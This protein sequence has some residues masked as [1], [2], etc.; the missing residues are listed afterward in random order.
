V[1]ATVVAV[2]SPHRLRWTLVVG[3]L[4]GLLALTRTNG[5]VVALPVALAL[6]GP[7][8]RWSWRALAPVALLLAVAAA[9]VAP[10]T[11]RNARAMDGFVPVGTEAGSALAGTYN[12]NAQEQWHYP[13]TWKWPALLPVLRPVLAVPKDEVAR[14]H[15]LIDYALDYVGD[16]PEAPFL[17]IATNTGR[18]FGTGGPRWW[19]H[20]AATMDVPELAGD[21]AMAWLALAAPLLLAGVYAAWRSRGPPWL[22]LVPLLLLLSAAVVVGELRFRAPIDPFLVLLAALGA[23]LVA[24]W[25]RRPAGAT[26]RLPSPASASGRARPSPSGT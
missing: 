4:L 18:L 16:H 7:S 15:Q 25:L 8:P 20:S 9:V 24:T 23:D 22:W 11:I 1:A 5:I 14:E 10:W 13:R 6:W 12:R 3:V 26:A 17:T 2:Q 21:A 19:R